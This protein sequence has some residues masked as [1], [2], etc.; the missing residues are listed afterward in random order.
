MSESLFSQSWYR[1]APLAPRLR[2]HVQMVRHCYRGAD[3]YVIQDRFTG[4]HH[5]FSPEAYALIGLMDGHR[6]LGEIWST[7]CARLGDHM[8][9]Q[10]E[11]IGL[12]SQLHR[13]DLI[14]TSVLS[15][16]S[17]LNRRLAQGQKNRL[18]TPLRS[19]LSLRFPIL[20]PDRFLNRT[21]PL[22]RPFLG[23]MSLLVWM[24]VVITGI[25]LAAMHWTDLSNNFSDRIFGLENLFLMSLIYPLLKA[26]HEFC[27]A[28][29]VKK[30]GGEVHEMGI[31][32]LVF[33]PIP[34]VD[35]SSSLAFREK[36]QRM[37]VGGAGILMEVFIAALAM[38]IWAHVEAGPIRAVA[39][40]VMLIAGVSTVLFNGN[41]LLRFDAYYV[42]ADFL[43]IPNLGQRSNSYMGYLAR[44]YWLGDRSL[45]SPA[46][47]S[48]EGFWLG[49]Y[50]LASFIYRIFISVR[51]ILFIAGKFFGLGLLLAAW[52][53][54]G[55][56]ILPLFRWIRFLVKDVHMQRKRLRIML[57]VALPIALMIGGLFVV[58][59]PLFTQC[60]GVTRAPDESRINAE[61]DG[62][63][64]EIFTRNGS[65]VEKG[66]P[67]L[68]LEDPRLGAHVRLLKARQEEYLARYTMSR[69]TDRT[70]TAVLR[71]ALSHI[72]AEL[73]RAEERL[74]SLTLCSKS[75][76]IFILP[77]EE[78]LPGRFAQRGTTLAYVLDGN[79]LTLR[80]LVTQADIERVR[81]DTRKVDVLLAENLNRVVSGSILREVPAASHE[82]PSLALSLEGGGRFALDPR[83]KDKPLTV[84]RLFQFDVRPDEALT[85]RMEERVYIRFHHPPEPLAWRWMR[86]TRRL[87]LSRFAV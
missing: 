82:L 39:F 49:I 43:E 3:W 10:D 51:I 85:D 8:P 17:D 70:E 37:L 20:D 32:L 1:V 72:N 66:T 7:V 80:V 87:L 52:S 16:F 38:L 22:V 71:E 63:V 28:Y 23:W 48:S 4:R 44:R 14:Q 25:S 77:D 45:T 40:N 36:S 31:M 75:A 84:A 69:M 30:W 34:Y 67:L 2:S 15:D 24:G 53:A 74:Q 61:T 47:S 68:R 11:V 29:M 62:F 86:D 55:L 41:P 35:A 5:R 57:T 73:T 42:L 6:T 60:E 18:L 65:R 12:L 46:E 54:F 79:L 76:G 59:L 21:L 26:L 81:S 56:V 50:A 27:H 64:A 13:F 33:M 9:T 58:P 78:D 19:P 83:K